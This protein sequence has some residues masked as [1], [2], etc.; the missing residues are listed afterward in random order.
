MDKRKV[1]YLR[2]SGYVN[3]IYV[4]EQLYVSADRQS[5]QMYGPN[6][7]HKYSDTVHQYSGRS[8]T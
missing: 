6:S 4:R 7:S 5:E 3:I 1:H 2:N 8:L